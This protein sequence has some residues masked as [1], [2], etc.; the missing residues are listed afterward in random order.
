MNNSKWGKLVASKSL[1]TWQICKNEEPYPKRQQ[2]GMNFSVTC[3]FVITIILNPHFNIES[4]K[5]RCDLNKSI[6]TTSRP[7]P[8]TAACV[9]DWMVVL[10]DI[11]SSRHAGKLKMLNSGHENTHK[12]SLYVTKEES[13]LENLSVKTPIA[14]GKANDERW[15]LLDDVVPSKLKNCNS[16]AER[17]NLLYNLI[18]NETVNIAPKGNLNC[19]SGSLKKGT[20]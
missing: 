19:P 18:Y 12:T 14:W 10:E 11:S 5:L 4:S 13:L 17:L 15:I 7:I 16:L 1:Q 20:Y 3:A 8:S 9:K 2:P 6:S